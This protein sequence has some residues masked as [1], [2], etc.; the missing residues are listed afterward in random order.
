[1]PVTKA[2]KKEQV[3]K[4]NADLKDVS[5]M[6]V[7]TYSK[8]TVAHDYELRKTLRG[9]GAKYKVVKNTLAQLAA[10]GT[11]VEEALKGLGGVTSIAYTSGDPVAMAKALSKYA[12]DTPEFTFKVGVVEGRVISIKEIESL[13]SMPS[14]GELMSKLLF[15]INAPAQRLVT[16]MNAVGRNLAVVVDQ[17]VQ[18][19]KFTE[20]AAAGV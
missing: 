18:Q 1:M 20:N 4:L 11:K 16:V 9:A 17:G 6:V 2:K 13:A 14:K 7:A 12:K 15:L 3:E 19:K 8:L 10:K 5:S